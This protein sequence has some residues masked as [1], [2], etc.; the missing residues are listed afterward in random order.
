MTLCSFIAVLG[1]T[2]RA[3]AAGF[4]SETSLAASSLARQAVTKVSA[5]RSSPKQPFAGF[6]ASLYQH[7]S[8]Y[9]SDTGSY[10]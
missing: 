10:E 7:V 1:A 5:A 8:K 6:E 3:P 2:N 9:L 4:S